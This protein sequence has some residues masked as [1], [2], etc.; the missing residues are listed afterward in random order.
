MKKRLKLIKR[1]YSSIL[2]VFLMADS[3][4]MKQRGMSENLCK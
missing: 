3:K 2:T 1:I 4:K